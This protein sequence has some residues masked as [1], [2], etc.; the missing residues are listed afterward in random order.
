[1]VPFEQFAGTNELQLTVTVLF[2][3]CAGAAR[4]FSKPLPS[5]IN[6][7]EQIKLRINFPSFLAEWVVLA[8]RNI[9]MY[10]AREKPAVR[11]G[12]CAGSCRIL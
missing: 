3:A 6:S 11:V 10:C 2:K 9:R 5:R 8:D 12:P 1:V 7:T 4:A